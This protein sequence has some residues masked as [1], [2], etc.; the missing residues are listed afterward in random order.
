M[1]NQSSVWAIPQPFHLAMSQWSKSWRCKSILYL[2]LIFMIAHLCINQCFWAF[3]FWLSALGSWLWKQLVSISLHWLLIA[4]ILLLFLFDLALSLLAWL[5]W[6]PWSGLPRL[7]IKIT[8][9]GKKEK[10]I[11]MFSSCHK[12]RKSLPAR[13]GVFLLPLFLIFIFVFFFSIW[14]SNSSAPRILDFSSIFPPL[15][16]PFSFIERICCSLSCCPLSLC[17]FSFSCRLPLPF[18]GAGRVWLLFCFDCPGQGF[19]VLGW[20]ELAQKQ[21]N[22]LLSF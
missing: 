9:E 18:F 15:F 11:F 3:R 16:M 6:L 14:F 17:T 5:A 13:P 7:G 20:K 19:E 2:T 21:E 4:L 12:Q 1:R 8:P 10:L 22:C